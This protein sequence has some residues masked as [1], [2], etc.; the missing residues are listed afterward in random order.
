MN[1]S[2]I[3]AMFN[4][5]VS[6]DAL[7]PVLQGIRFEESR[8]I[9]TDCKLLVV[10]KETN[11]KLAGK[12]M[13]IR[14]EEIPGQFPN[15]DRV[16]PSED[17]LE[18]YKFRI[19]PAHLYKVTGWF[20]RLSDA[21]TNDAVVI[22]GKA[23]IIRDLHKLLRVFSYANE[24]PE[25]IFYKTPN[26]RPLVVRSKSL[27]ALLMPFHIS[28]V[29]DIDAERKEGDSIKISYENLLNRFAFESW[30]TKPVA[31]PYAWLDE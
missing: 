24:L 12:T 31:Q 28:D 27:H 1:K 30:Q 11:P 5:I 25:T 18:T 29:S 7:R 6:R 10:Y 19:D 23:F 8:C 14:G 20:M 2:V 26:G 17:S 21:N 9:A 22:D 15:V 16:F 3:I 13:N 4:D